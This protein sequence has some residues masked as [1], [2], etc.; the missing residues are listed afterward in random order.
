MLLFFVLSTVFFAGTTVGLGYL[1]RKSLKAAALQVAQV[2]QAD[3]AKVAA[4]VATK[5]VAKA[6][7][8]TKTGVSDVAATPVEI[9]YAFVIE[10]SLYRHNSVATL[11]VIIFDICRCRFT[12]LLFSDFI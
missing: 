11:A 9:V 2:A 6:V 3:Y 7:L 5:D 12:V 1:Y 4:D 10:S 8:D